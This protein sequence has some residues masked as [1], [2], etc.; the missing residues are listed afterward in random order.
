MPWLTIRTGAPSAEDATDDPAP[1]SV[2]LGGDESLTVAVD[3][4]LRALIARYCRRPVRG[5]EGTEDSAHA[6]L[7][8]G[9]GYGVRYAADGMAYGGHPRYEPIERRILENELPSVD[10][11]V[12]HSVPPGEELMYRLY[13]LHCRLLLDILDV[14]AKGDA[15][16]MARLMLLIAA[17][18]PA[19]DSYRYAAAPL[20]RQTE[21][22]SE[23]VHR[24]A[25][26]VVRA[27]PDPVSPNWLAQA[28]ADAEIVTLVVPGAEGEGGRREV[29]IGQLGSV[30]ET[31]AARRSLAG[32]LENE[33]NR[34]IRVAPPILRDS[35]LE[36]AKTFD[37]LRHGR[38][39][40]YARAV[41]KAEDAAWAALRRYEELVRYLYAVE[42]QNA[43]Y[44]RIYPFHR[45]VVHEWMQARRDL[46]PEFYK[47]LEEAG[48]L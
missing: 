1:Y 33:F 48:D 39:R 43:D 37:L 11:L 47:M 12:E 38:T 19:A 18:R 17:G 22:H 28:L 20:M 23:W 2:V 5:R 35:L 30:L 4:I 26:A 36:Y 29:P 24:R 3:A 41:K 46:L 44:Q 25:V 10:A 32:Q 27:T 13:A 6:W 15:S 31:K 45:Y 40:R 16:P 42:Q 8:A 14:K 34:L 21:T 9:I 7:A